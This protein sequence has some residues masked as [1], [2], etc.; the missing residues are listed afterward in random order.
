MKIE[1]TTEELNRT[2]LGMFV[3]MCHTGYSR[4]ADLTEA[5]YRQANQFANAVFRDARIK[6]TLTLSQNYVMYDVLEWVSGKKSVSPDWLLCWC[7]RWHYMYKDSLSVVA[8]P[9]KLALRAVVSNAEQYLEDLRRSE[10]IVF[11][12]ARYSASN[13][14]DELSDFL[15]AYMLMQQ[16]RH[17][18]IWHSDVKQLL[19]YGYAKGKQAERQRRRAKV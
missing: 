11:I 8:D 4:I 15:D 12:E 10:R 17:R 7:N 9:D 13:L 14:P 5:V 19:A 18:K 6:P 1:M 16:L 2:A 3:D